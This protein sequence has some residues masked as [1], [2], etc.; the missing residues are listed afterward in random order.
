L[1][2]R[3]IGMATKA[4]RHTG[5]DYRNPSTPPRCRELQCA[6]IRVRREVGIPAIDKSE[7][8]LLG[9]RADIPTD[10]TVIPKIKAIPA[11]L[12]AHNMQL[13]TDLR[14]SGLPVGLPINC[15]ALRLNDG[16]RH[17]AG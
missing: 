17:F 4:H 11:L 16:L 7:P 1:T 5:P 14:M 8:L 15:H 6:G 3:I 13:Q 9:F 12:P 2:E 10:E